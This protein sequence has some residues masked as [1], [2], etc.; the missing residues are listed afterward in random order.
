MDL[1]ELL[2]KTPS[3]YEGADDDKA[4]T[5]EDKKE[6]ANLSNTAVAKMDL[7]ELLGKIPGPYEGADDDKAK[8]VEDKKELANL[9]NTAVAAPLATTKT[10]VSVLEEGC[11]KYYSGAAPVFTPDFTESI[12]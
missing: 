6:L 9:S 2:G 12:R 5:V 4:K 10:F 3:T 1:D 7:D 8:T 11:R